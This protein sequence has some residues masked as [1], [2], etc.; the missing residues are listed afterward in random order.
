MELIEEGIIISLKN[1]SDT[2]KIASILTRHH[3]MWKGLVQGNLCLDISD[4]VKLHWKSRNPEGLGNFFFE[5]IWNNFAINAQYPERLLMIKSAAELCLAYLPQR[6]PYEKLFDFLEENVKSFS[7]ETYLL[8]ELTFL[9]CLGFPLDF[10]KCSVTNSEGD[11]YY[12][13]PKTGRS[14]CREVGEK[15]KDKLFVIPNIFLHP[16]KPSTPDKAQVRNDT[17]RALSI[18][19]YFLKKNIINSHKS[20]FF[21]DK[22]LERIKHGQNI[23]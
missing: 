7:I 16:S 6:E 11:V 9:E 23:F 18:T 1:F 12:L 17:L 13:S 15:Y 22:I 10:S 21:R 14:V 19:E 2:K 8:F 3:G 20:L 4:F 5:D